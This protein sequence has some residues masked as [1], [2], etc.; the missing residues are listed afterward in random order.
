MEGK[1]NWLDALSIVLPGLRDLLT[2]KVCSPA[3]AITGASVLLPKPMVDK[4][5][6]EFS[7]ENFRQLAREMMRLEIRFF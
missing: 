5:P 7:N 2:D 3:V 4:E 6:M 1:Q